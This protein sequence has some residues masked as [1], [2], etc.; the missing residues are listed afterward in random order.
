[1]AVHW[2]D[3]LVEELEARLKRRAKEEY[4]FNGGLSVSGL[5]HVGRLRGEVLLGEAVRR[6]LERRGFKVKQLLTLYTVDPWKGKDEQRSEFPDPEAARKY[7]AGPSI[8]CPILGA[9]TRVG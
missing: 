5:Q 4:V 1:M 8:R 7:V 2:V 9:A 3:K 6:E